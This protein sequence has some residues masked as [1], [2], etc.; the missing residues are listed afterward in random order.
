MKYRNL[1]FRFPDSISVVKAVVKKPTG[2][3]LIGY[4]RTC[5]E[6]YAHA[7]GDTFLKA[8]E[9]YEEDYV[10][11]NPHPNDQ[12]SEKICHSICKHHVTD[13]EYIP[14]EVGR[15]LASLILERRYA[16]AV[17][18]CYT[19]CWDWAFE[20]EEEPAVII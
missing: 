16:D 14:H 1:S 15:F 19:Y 7:G 20:D 6:A 12:D 4:G 9:L 2:E 13:D 3:V 5:E 18:F 17:Q 10:S 8:Q 11:N